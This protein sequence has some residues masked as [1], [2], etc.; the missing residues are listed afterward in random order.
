MILLYIGAVMEIAQIVYI[1]YDT[2]PEN[3]RTENESNERKKEI[4]RLVFCIVAHVF[5]GI[6][7]AYVSIYG[8][9]E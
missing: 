2:D 1:L 9:P 4:C 3:Q 7:C 5:F 6:G 8:Y